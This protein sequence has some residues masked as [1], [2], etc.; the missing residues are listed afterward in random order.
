MKSKLIT[1]PTDLYGLPVYNKA[2]EHIGYIDAFPNSEDIKLQDLVEND[3]TI[4]QEIENNPDAIVLYLE[5][6]APKKLKVNFENVQ[7]QE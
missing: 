7:K 3:P 5:P 4:L 2:G 1:K 6:P